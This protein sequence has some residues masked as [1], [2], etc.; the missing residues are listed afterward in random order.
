MGC[1]VSWNPPGSCLPEFSQI[2]HF[3]C[4]LDSLGPW[5]LRSL[6][7]QLPLNLDSYSRFCWFPWFLWWPWFLSPPHSCGS[8]LHPILLVLHVLV[9]SLWFL[10]FLYGFLLFRFQVDSTNSSSPWFLSFSMVLQISLLKMSWYL[11][12]SHN[13]WWWLMRSHGITWRL[14]ASHDVSWCLEICHGSCV[15]WCPVTS[16]GISCFIGSHDDTWCLMM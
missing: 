3:P 4:F 14:M 8:S 6:V 2:F 11:M 1:C 5:F 15:L 13:I 16:Y 9:L 12:V 7:P 10:R